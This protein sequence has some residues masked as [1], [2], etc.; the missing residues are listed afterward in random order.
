M[1]YNDYR[2]TSARWKLKEVF[3]CS[4]EP[5]LEGRCVGMGGC[6]RA[7]MCVGARMRACWHC[8]QAARRCFSGSVAACVQGAPACILWLGCT[9]AGLHNRKGLHAHERAL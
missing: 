7:C 8:V 9:G 3:F 2:F 4:L 1:E 5:W 6:M